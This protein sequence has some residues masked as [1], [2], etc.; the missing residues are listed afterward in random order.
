MSDKRTPYKMSDKSIWL[1]LLSRLGDKPLD[2]IAYESL[3]E[4]NGTIPYYG[5]LNQ[6]NSEF[7]GDYPS[8]LMDILEP[9]RFQNLKKSR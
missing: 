9:K 8:Q 3:Q 2:Q 6:P 5:E 7:K 1:S 4:S